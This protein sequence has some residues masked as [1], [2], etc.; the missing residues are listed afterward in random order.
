M[1]NELK[2]SFYLRHKEEKKDGTVP[3]MGRI[4]IEK[5]MAQFSAKCSV[6]VSIWDT[7]AA[8]AIGKSK[9]ATELNRTLDMI[10]LAIHTSNKEQVNRIGNATATEVKN[11]FQ[12]IASGQ[13]TLLAYCDR[14]YEELGARV[15][16]NLTHRSLE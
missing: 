4:P 6:A 2:V 15:G 9:V 5:S 13:I 7:K 11:A 12:G 8:R 16:V 1:S 10:T 14:F 3:I